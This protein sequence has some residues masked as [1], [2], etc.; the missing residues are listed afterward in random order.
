[1]FVALMTGICSENRRKL[2]KAERRENFQT[3][4]MEK[5]DLLKLEG[6]VGVF[7]LISNSLV[8]EKPKMVGGMSD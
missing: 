8:T 1:M 7:S 4:C 2:I 3:A 6:F 5:G